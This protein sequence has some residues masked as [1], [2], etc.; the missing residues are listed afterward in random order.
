MVLLLRYVFVS[1]ITINQMD[2]LFLN[3][4][5]FNDFMRLIF[6]TLW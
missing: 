6:R 3:Y 4:Q 2:T 1:D 5:I